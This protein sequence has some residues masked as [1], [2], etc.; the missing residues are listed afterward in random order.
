VEG[1]FI[2]ELVGKLKEREHLGDV[3]DDG[4]IILKFILKFGW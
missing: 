4:L 3:E 2:E 1:M